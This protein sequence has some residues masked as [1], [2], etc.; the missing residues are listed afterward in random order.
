MQNHKDLDVWQQAIFL[1]I[2]SGSAAEL[3]RYTDR[4]IKKDRRTG[5]CSGTGKC[6]SKNNKNPA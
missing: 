4:N 3:A 1:Y 5:E 6:T 2:A